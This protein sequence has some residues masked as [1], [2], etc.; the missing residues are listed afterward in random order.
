MSKQKKSK[1]SCSAFKHEYLCTNYIMKGQEIYQFV[2]K[3]S[4]KNK[5]LDWHV[6]NY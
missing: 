2:S 1:Y 4:K 5:S 3:I 6:D